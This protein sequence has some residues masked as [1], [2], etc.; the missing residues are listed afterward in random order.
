[1]LLSPL[2]KDTEVKPLHF[3]KAEIPMLLTVD[4]IWTEVKDEQP[5]N[6]PSPMLVTPSRLISVKLSQYAKV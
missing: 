2:E 3:S 1:M 4:G 6:A 5:S